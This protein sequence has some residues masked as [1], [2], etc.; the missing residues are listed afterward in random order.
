MNNFEINKN[1]NTS[2]D[3]EQCLHEGAYLRRL[4]VGAKPALEYLMSEPETPLNEAEKEE[5][6]QF[7]LDLLSLDLPSGINIEQVLAQKYTSTELVPTVFSYP[8]LNNKLDFE[9][10][11]N[12]N[13]NNSE[14]FNI[15]FALQIAS[16]E[17]DSDQALKIAK[18][19]QA[20]YQE[21]IAENII[22]DS[23]IDRS[24][25]DNRQFVLDKD[26]LLT[27]LDQQ[28]QSIEIIRQLE[29]ESSDKD[30]LLSQAK[31]SYCRVARRAILAKFV[32]RGAN[33]ITL[34]EQLKMSGSE[35]QNQVNE[36]EASI[37]STI[38]KSIKLGRK[39]KIFE[40]YDFYRNGATIRQN[41]ARVFSS[42][43]PDLDSQASIVN[44]D[45]IFSED[46]IAKMRA[47]KIKPEQIKAFVEEVI[48]RAGFSRDQLG[49]DGIKAVIDR[50]KTNM[51]I[52]STNPKDLTFKIGGNDRSIEDVITIALAHEFEH[53]NQALAG[54]K[55][56]QNL[57]IFSL[58]VRRK[59]GLKEAGALRSE[60]D[61]RYLYFGSTKPR[62]NTY[63]LALKKMEE[64]GDL[65]E[66]IKA[67]YQEKIKY[68]PEMDKKEAAK[69]AADR[70]IRFLRFG[71]K[72]S[73]PLSYAEALLLEEELSDC[74]NEIKKRATALTSLNLA[75]QVELHK[76][77][78]I[79]DLN[80]DGVDWLKIG[81]ELLR[82]KGYIE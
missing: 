35:F 43:H 16:G 17:I 37:P 60:N 64:T 58:G 66:A 72:N 13:F 69:E 56:A 38:R 54:K 34:L 9:E 42:L 63:G 2:K 25:L 26:K 46:Q 61:I 44:E 20:Y 52:E 36:V 81:L 22:N 79:P 7:E 39:D 12:Q 49:D 75:D 32:E 68:F 41:H 71:G 45:P 30:D 74:D 78:L 23:E 8:I 47:I 24:L 5:I 15:W 29:E 73:Q 80:S 28:K 33:A 50:S 3:I 76:F 55:A 10:L 27:Q 48:E 18:A 19:S 82:E 57:K 77:G 40:I 14:E 31:V 11:K 21:E 70:V 51:S 65:S 6:K 59:S 62:A 67:F 53:V 1:F 4:G